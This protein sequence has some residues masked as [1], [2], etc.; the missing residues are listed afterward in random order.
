MYG[1]QC[2][3]G[4][5]AMSKLTSRIAP[6]SCGRE[7]RRGRSARGRRR[8]WRGPSG[9]RSCQPSASSRPS[10][11]P[12]GAGRPRGVA[13]GLRPALGDPGDA[14]RPG[15]RRRGRWACR[16][17][18]SRDAA[19]GWVSLD[20]SPPVPPS[21]QGRSLPS[22]RADVEGAGAGRAVEGLVAGEGEQVDRRGL[23]VDRHHAGRLR[24]VDEEQGPGLA[25]D[26]GDLPRSAGRSPG[27]SRRGSWRRAR[28]SGVRAP[29]TSSGSR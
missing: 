20:E 9:R 5:T 18:G 8:G 29:R 11:R 12:S 19:S 14:R 4:R 23:Q 16:L 17:R 13:V 6:R 3:P 28:S 1:A 10:R 7:R 15:R 27:R 22:P 24:G 21:R 26:R 25:D 2:R